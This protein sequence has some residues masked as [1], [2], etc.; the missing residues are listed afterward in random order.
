[1]GDDDGFVAVVTGRSGIA[2]AEFLSGASA[3]VFVED[4]DEH[5]RSGEA[6]LEASYGMGMKRMHM[7][8]GL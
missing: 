2:V 4:V 8:L 6:E 3:G 5:V 1:M 7:G